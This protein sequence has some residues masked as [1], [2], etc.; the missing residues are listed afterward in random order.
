[1]HFPYRLIPFAVRLIFLI[2]F[3]VNSAAGAIPKSPM[4]V[5]PPL[6]RFAAVADRPTAEF[7]NSES[8]YK[9]NVDEKQLPLLALPEHLAAGFE[10]SLTYPLDQFH[11]PIFQALNYDDEHGK[12]LLPL[13]SQANTGIHFV[14][15]QPSAIRNM[16]ASVDGT[17]IQLTD[18]DTL[19]TFRTS[20]GTKYIFVRYPDGE[21]RCAS[22]RQ[23]NGATLSLLYA[24]NGLSLHGVVDSSGRTLTFNYANKSIQSIT[25]TWMANSEGKTKTWPVGDQLKDLADK[26]AKYSHAVG[27]GALKSIPMNA[28]IR[29]YTAEMAASDKM[30]AQIFGGPNAVAGANGF[31]P[32]GL[33]A[34]YPLYR[35]DI[36]GDDGKVRRGHLSYGMHLYGSSDGQSDS[37]LYVPAG[38]TS[39]SGEAT[40]TDA[41]VTFYYPR[42]GN[43]TDVTVAIFHVTN[44]QISYEGDRVKIGNIGG[45][46]GSSASY[47]HSHIEFYRGNTGLPSA[48]ARPGLRIDPASVFAT[49]ER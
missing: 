27:S 19:K 14:E 49:A 33:A 4:R 41:A 45:P 35:G 28:V 38:F 22:I 9:W 31:E 23:A 1:M 29:L 32:A 26:S 5:K 30:L 17:N 44:F 13:T 25:Q 21:F 47:K 20:D 6:M 34:S 39:H 48:A 18:L 3:L 10:R 40:P 36:I 12:Y 7:S 16:F 46:G 42:L 43:L 37:P 15:F 2:L 8:A 11:F 24:A